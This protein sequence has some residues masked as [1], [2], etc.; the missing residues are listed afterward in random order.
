MHSYILI[1][2]RIPSKYIPVPFENLTMTH[3]TKSGKGTFVFTKP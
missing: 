1:Y 3:K 2:M